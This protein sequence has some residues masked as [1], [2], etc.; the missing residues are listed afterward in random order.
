M[1]GLLNKA[2]AVKESEAAATAAPKKLNP[3]TPDRA[4]S[5]QPSPVLPRIGWATIV[6]AG[7]LS[8]QGGAIGLVIVCLVA[9]VGVGLLVQHERMQPELNTVKVSISVVLAVLI[10]LGPYAALV[11][12]PQDSSMALTQIEMDQESDEVT[13]YVRGSFSSSTASISSGGEELWTGS[14]DLNNDFAKYR[15][16]VSSF[17]QG[18]AQDNTGATI[19]SYEISI[20]SDDGQTETREIPPT[21]MN[22]EVLESG[23]KITMITKTETSSSS[24]D[25]EVDGLLVESI[26][27]LFGPS[28]EAEDGGDHSMSTVSNYLPVFSDYTIQIKVMKGSSQKWQSP[29]ISVDGTEATWVSAVS[30]SKFG[31]TDRW[32]G[33]SGTGYDA[34]TGMIEILKKEDFYDNAGCYTFQVV[35]TNEYYTGETSTQSSSSAWDLDFSNEDGEMSAC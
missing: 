17:F 24:T 9:L 14:E 3:A 5:E 7:I 6:I 19:K 30:G 31:S 33:I 4:G 1:S 8:L 20:E 35:V 25:T 27:G 26:V 32:M 16:P 22:R 10:S 11:L 28:E 21:F 15:V 12:I 18:N 2:T 34:D 29:I 23:A 13:F